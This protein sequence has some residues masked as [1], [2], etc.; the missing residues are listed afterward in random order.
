[1]PSETTV[2][3]GDIP[4]NEGD[5]CALV[6]PTGTWRLPT[7]AEYVELIKTY[8]VTT[9]DGV[10]GMNLGPDADFLPCG[11]LSA[12]R[13]TARLRLRAVIGPVT[14]RAGRKDLS[15]VLPLRPLPNPM[16]I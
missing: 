9:I 16:R 11:R 4:Y 7:K 14:K 5:P 13:P 1:M 2:A 3:W 12:R 10:A 15:S 8:E 6:A